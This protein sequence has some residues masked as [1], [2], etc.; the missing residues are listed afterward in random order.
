MPNTTTRRLK[1]EQV[2]KIFVAHLAPAI[3]E[4]GFT[5]PGRTM[6]RFRGPMVDVVDIRCGKYSER[7]VLT[8]GFGIRHFLDR[9]PKPV[10]CILRYRPPFV[11]ESKGP[12]VFRESEE[13]QVDAMLG[14]RDL[15]QTEA[16]SWF[17]LVESRVSILGE[18]QDAKWRGLGSNG[19]IRLGSP[20]HLELLRQLDWLLTNQAD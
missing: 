13:S 6:R 1:W 2:R 4:L 19:Q 8:F 10:D 3:C 16:R 7:A 9:N 14:A 18:A 5:G 15:L 20:I 11:D 17:S 12:L